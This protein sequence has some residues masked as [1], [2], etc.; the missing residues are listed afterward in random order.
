MASEAITVRSPRYDPYTLELRPA[1]LPV[2][3]I[4]VED[5]GRTLVVD[6]TGV[7]TNGSIVAVPPS[8]AVNADGIPVR[9][10]LPINVGMTAAEYLLSKRLVAGPFT[11]KTTWRFLCAAN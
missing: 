7:V 2:E 3:R 6:V 10:V 8:A 1:Q 11:S 4:A 5:D 9:D